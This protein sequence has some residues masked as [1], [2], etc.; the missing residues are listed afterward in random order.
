MCGKKVPEVLQMQI[1]VTESL[2]EGIGSTINCIPIGKEPIKFRWLDAWRN[3]ISLELDESGSEAKNVPPGNYF[4]Y[5]TDA[6]SKETMLKVTVKQCSLPVVIGYE[7][8]NAS[9]QVSR[10]GKV[11]AI[12][13]PKIY[14]AQYLW[15]TGALTKEPILVDVRCGVYSVTIVSENDEVPI[16]FVHATKPAIVNVGCNM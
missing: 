9:T 15:S 4:V 10:D 16:P 1:T 6:N 7:T 12:I 8:V 3:E 13:V 11:S 2:N 5:A 14:N